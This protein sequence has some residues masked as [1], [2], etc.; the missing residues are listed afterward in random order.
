MKK[1]TVPEVLLL[2]QKYYAKPGNLAGGYLHL[3]LDD[4]NID[5][6]YVEFCLKYAGENH[7]AD[8]V[9]LARLLLQMSLAQREKLYKSAMYSIRF[10]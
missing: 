3:V 8:G 1:P 7:D 9:E 5:D 4:G 6:D 10:V 2:V